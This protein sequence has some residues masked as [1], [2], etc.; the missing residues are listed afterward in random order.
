MWPA[1]NKGQGDCRIETLWVLDGSLLTSAQSADRAFRVPDVPLG[2]AAPS[3]SGGAGKWLLLFI[4]LVL[5]S[6]KKE[7]GRGS[8]TLVESGRLSPPGILKERLLEVVR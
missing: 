8:H 6:T 3:S 4:R 1:E 5:G 2:E 7:P